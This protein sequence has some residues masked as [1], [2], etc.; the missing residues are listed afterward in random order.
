MELNDETAKLYM[1]TQNY[2]NKPM[3][4]LWNHRIARAV[5][6]VFHPET[7]SVGQGRAAGQAKRDN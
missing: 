1:K 6:A 7:M 3:I 4:C 2:K 5:Q